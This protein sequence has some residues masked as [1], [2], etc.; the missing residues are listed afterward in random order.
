[1]P[2]AD[3][4]RAMTLNYLAEL[5]V[6][7]ERHAEAEVLYRQ[8]TEVIEA[9]L[10]PD[11]LDLAAHLA[12][13]AAFYAE[14]GIYTEAE[15]HYE[16]AVAI[17]EP[18]LGWAHSD[19]AANF[20]SLAS[21][22]HRQGLHAE[23]EPLFERALAV[24]DLA[25]EPDNVR[26]AEILEEYA[27]L[28]RATN[29]GVEAGP[30]EARAAHPRDAVAFRRSPAKRPSPA[31]FASRNNRRRT[32][33]TPGSAPTSTRYSTTLS[34]CSAS[35]SSSTVRPAASTALTSMPRSTA[36]MTASRVRNSAVGAPPYGTQGRA[37]RPPIPKAAIRA[38]VR[39]V[40]HC[41]RPSTM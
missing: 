18:A 9:A 15:P 12:T 28:L 11:H 1:S 8:A 5:C 32:Q 34:Y 36:S 7:E 21:V 31:G 13:V 39:S 38:V 35:A 24:L 41:M 25:L 30:L 23:A 17:M 37:R 20:A 27:E 26:L 19:L 4:R 6:A 29:R 16:R 14:Q 2:P 40:C 22:Y 33:F 10:G 3:L